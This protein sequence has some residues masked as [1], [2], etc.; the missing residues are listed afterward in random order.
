[1][2][3]LTIKGL[4]DALYERIRE[5]AALSHRSINSEVIAR[6][7]QALG[8]PR[9]EPAQLLER[10]RAVR[11]RTGRTRLTDR[12]LRDAKTGGRP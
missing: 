6:L 3:N 8:S 10:V 2:A 12:F 1:M 7:E 5:S 11:A 4:P 9:V